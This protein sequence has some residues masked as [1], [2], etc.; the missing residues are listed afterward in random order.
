VSGTDLHYF[1]HEQPREIE[2]RQEFAEA[3]AA[4]AP[5]TKAPRFLY[6]VRHEPSEGMTDRHW[7]EWIDTATGQRVERED[8]C[9]FFEWCEAI[10]EGEARS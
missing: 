4:V 5:T 3:L 1:E 8:L 7:Y 6:A 10:L 9:G 2:L